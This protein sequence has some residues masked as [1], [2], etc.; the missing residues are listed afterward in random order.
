MTQ[1][2]LFLLGFVVYILV[3]VQR[4]L[5]PQVEPTEEKEEEEVLGSAFPHSPR[6]S[7]WS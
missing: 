4:R 1:M 5:H 7:F 2:M 6:V 3:T